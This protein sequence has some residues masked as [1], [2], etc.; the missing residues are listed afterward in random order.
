MLLVH[1]HKIETMNMGGVRD[2]QAHIGLSRRNACGH[3]S[4]RAFLVP[5][6]LESRG[7][8]ISFLQGLIQQQTGAGTGAAVDKAHTRL[9][10]IGPIL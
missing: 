2:A 8:K 10:Q 1:R 5:I 3:G 4:V 7:L 9:V 6:A